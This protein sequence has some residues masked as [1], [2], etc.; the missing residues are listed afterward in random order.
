ML[1]SVI[2]FMHE[3]HVLSGLKS[4]VILCEPGSSVSTV[5]GYELEDRAIQAR[6]SAE[7]KNF[8]LS[9]CV[10]TGSGASG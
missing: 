6:S 9:S 4:T 1:M 8:R 3:T 10:Q 7:A 2:I 5:S